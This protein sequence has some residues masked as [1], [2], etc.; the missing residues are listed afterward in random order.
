MEVRLKALPAS[1]PEKPTLDECMSMLKAYK[2]HAKGLSKLFTV[3]VD[4]ESPGYD[5]LARVAEVDFTNDMLHTMNDPLKASYEDFSFGMS[6]ALEF[7]DSFD[8]Y[9]IAV[10]RMA[11]SSDKDA[12]AFNQLLDDHVTDFQSEL[13][14]RLCLLWG[15]HPD[16]TA[17][18]GRVLKRWGSLRAKK[19]P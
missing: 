7:K 11:A 16:N 5:R 6:V 3:D 9:A 14:S 19:S 18:L 8:E 4:H 12:D 2:A 1:V 15:Y 17:P 10:R 13:G